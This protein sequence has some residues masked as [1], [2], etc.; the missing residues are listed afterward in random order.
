MLWGETDPRTKIIF[1]F[2]NIMQ[3]K[4]F[5][6]VF[7]RSVFLQHC[8]M[9]RS[10]LYACNKF[11]DFDRKCASNLYADALIAYSEISK[12]YVWVHT[13]HKTIKIVF[14]CINITKYHVKYRNILCKRLIVKRCRVILKQLRFTP[15]YPHHTKSIVFCK[16]LKRNIIHLFRLNA[17]I[18]WLKSR[19]FHMIC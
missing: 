14:V 7:C 3:T 18:L 8:F 9:K 6:F 17:D 19:K 15:L 11:S 12:V 10:S 13:Q 16:Q 1:S 5:F 4:K 2:T